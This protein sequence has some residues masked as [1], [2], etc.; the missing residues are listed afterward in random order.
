MEKQTDMA[1][2]TFYAVQGTAGS[3]RPSVLLC[4]RGD[5]S[6]KLRYANNSNYKND[7][8][9][10]KEAYVHKSVMEELKRI[11]DDSEITK[12][13]DALWPPP[14]RVGRQELEIVIGDEH[15]SF[16]TSKIGSLIDVNQSKDPE[17]LRVFY[18][19]VQDLKCL[20]FSLIGLHFKIKPI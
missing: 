14:D 18:Y 2:V 10:R 15:I 4:V 1:V 3:A 20:V 9:I 13:D 19:L 11:I 16:T 12:E 8:M 17:G 6:R 7:V 5:W